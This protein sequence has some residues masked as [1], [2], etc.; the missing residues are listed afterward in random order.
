MAKTNY[1]LY[2]V[3]LVIYDRDGSLYVI[4][5]DNTDELSEEEIRNKTSILFKLIL[6]TG[7]YKKDLMKSWYR[8]K[9]LTKSELEKNESELKKNDFKLCEHM[10]KNIEIDDE[11][12]NKLCEYMAQNGCVI[13]IRK[14]SYN[15]TL[16]IPQ[17]LEQIYDQLGI[18][19]K[20][21][22]NRLHLSSNLSLIMGDTA[23]IENKRIKSINN[24]PEEVLRIIK[25]NING[26][27]DAAKGNKTIVV[28]GKGDIHLQNDSDYNSYEGLLNSLN[29]FMP[30]LVEGIEPEKYSSRIYNK[31][32]KNGGL[33]LGFL[34][35]S[36]SFD[37]S[38]KVLYIPKNIL[39]NELQLKTLESILK[40]YED[41][42]KSNNN[43]P[44]SLGSNISL[45]S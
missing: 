32:F 26:Y 28:S 29:R 17:R 5:E 37:T 13:M 33:V 31:L 15:I 27:L 19:I 20:L 42:R 11:K 41:M 43:L 38:Q 30:E 23:I 21:I 2:K 16:Y 35:N 22:L 6:K 24:F 4:Q 45:S 39:D 40:E 3:D 25:L 1:S 9:I 18:S 14:N 36:F 10:F 12:F 34:H 8:E 44:F 7:I